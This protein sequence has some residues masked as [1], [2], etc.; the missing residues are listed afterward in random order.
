MVDTLNRMCG[1]VE[2]SVQLKGSLSFILFLWAGL[3]FLALLLMQSLYAPL[4]D[5]A[6]TKNSGTCAAEH[7][8]A[9]SK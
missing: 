9:L 4:S 6:Y 3:L 8:T 7:D 5:Y 1:P 2:I